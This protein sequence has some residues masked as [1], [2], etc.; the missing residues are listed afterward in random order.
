MI[1]MANVVVFLLHGL[2]ATPITLWPLEQYL[3]AQ[4]HE[5]THRLSYPVDTLEFSKLIDYVDLEMSK[6]AD[7]KTDEIV[8]IGQS[9]GGVVSNRIWTKGW[10]VK[11]AVYIGSPLHGARLI[12]KLENMAPNW[13]A[14]LL[15]KKVPYDFLKT[16][17]PEPEPPHPYNTVTMSWIG[18]T[19]FD[20]CV[21]KDEAVLDESKNT[22]LR[23]AD[24]RLIFANPRLWML[25]AQILNTEHEDSM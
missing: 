16:K 14:N 2:G 18:T 13:L 3:R 23:W 8:L 20:G 17:E 9:M 5:R 6:H 24:H 11:H 1:K 22:H 10:T 7:K 19:D 4:G 12:S 21:Y 15:Y 25:V